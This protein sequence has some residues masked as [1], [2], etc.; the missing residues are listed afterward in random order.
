[1]QNAHCCSEFLQ[2]VKAASRKKIGSRSKSRTY[3]EGYKQRVEKSTEA[4]M[5]II[6][7]KRDAM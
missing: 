3:L 1:M 2:S 5:K 6:D 4:L 7:G